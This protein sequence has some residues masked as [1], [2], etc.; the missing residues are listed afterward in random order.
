MSSDAQRRRVVAQS[1]GVGNPGNNAR[2]LPLQADPRHDCQIELEVEDILPYEHNPRRALNARFA[3][4]KDSIRACGI[5]S[6]LAVTRRPGEAHFIVEAGG[7]SRLLAIQQ[8]WAETREVRFQ[9]LMVLFRPWRSETDVLTAHLIEN[10]LRGEMTF[11]DKASGVVALK[12]QLLASTGHMLS[13]RQL[14]AELKRLG[15]SVNTA[16][17]AHYLFATE[18]LGILGEAITDLSG[19]DVKII[20]PRLNLMKRYAQMRASHDE[21]ALYATVFDPVFRRHADEYRRTQVFSASALCLA[22][23]EALARQLGEPVTEVRT[24]LN[25]LAQSPQASLETLL[26]QGSLNRAAPSAESAP[27]AGN[28]APEGIATV[29]TANTEIARTEKLPRPIR[30]ALHSLDGDAAV[31]RRLTEQIGRFASLAGVS[32]RLHLHAAAPLGYVMDAPLITAD[33]DA[34]Q[35]LRDRAWWLLALISGQLDEGAPASRPDACVFDAG[36]LGWLLD[37]N[38]EAAGVFWDVVALVRALPASTRGRRAIAERAPNGAGG[39]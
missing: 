35:P 37:A 1:L 18:R 36:V 5:R 39:T 21:A 32:D 19:L 2:D 30:P 10:E 29:S 17:L 23:E 16:T 14:E 15:M 27:T 9:K 3:E 13:L 20:Q 12:A 34:Q 33:G 38:D 11:W 7:N 28:P 4:I 8:L 26:A 24:M 22:C 25:T 31:L 6:P